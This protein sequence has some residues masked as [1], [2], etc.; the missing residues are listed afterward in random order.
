MVEL[1][2]KD[3]DVLIAYLAK[4]IITGDTSPKN[5]WLIHQLLDILNNNKY[6]LNQH[7][8]NTHTLNIHN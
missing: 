2:V 3:A 5:I 4:Q 8:H 6:V 7:T 1:D